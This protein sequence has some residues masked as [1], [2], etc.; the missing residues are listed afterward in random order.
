MRVSEVCLLKP[1]RRVRASASRSDFGGRV[2]SIIRDANRLPNGN[3]LIASATR[4][5]EITARGQIVWQM[6]RSNLGDRVKNAKQ[7]FKAI[8]IAPDGTA[9]GG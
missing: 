5:V 4:L 1:I 9:Y 6:K 7:F 8:R 2:T 3:I